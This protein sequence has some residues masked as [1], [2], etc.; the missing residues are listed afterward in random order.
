MAE[1]RISH[2]VCP[3]EAKKKVKPRGWQKLVLTKHTHTLT[4]T[5]AH[6]YVLAHT[7]THTGVHSHVRALTHRYTLARVH[8]HTR[9][10]KYKRGL[11]Q[12]PAPLCLAGAGGR[13]G[14]KP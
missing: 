1:G 2:F 4:H 12:A 5:S 14:S 13:V 11:G 9:I 8:A 7:R 10:H 3:A 6:T